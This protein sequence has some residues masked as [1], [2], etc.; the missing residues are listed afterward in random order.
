M[1]SLPPPRDGQASASDSGRKP[2]AAPPDVEMRADG[3]YDSREAF[4]YCDSRGI[5][6]YTRI[7]TNA[8]CRAR[9]AS[10]ARS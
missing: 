2:A 5:T 7:R 10:T 4:S 6:P 3:G 8:G 1:R 9:G